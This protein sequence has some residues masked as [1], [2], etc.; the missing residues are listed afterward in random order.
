MTTTGELAD[1]Q[2]RIKTA[3]FQSQLA[4]TSAKF[5]SPQSG[6]KD[7]AVSDEGL[8]HMSEVVLPISILP[9]IRIIKT[10]L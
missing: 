3:P 7:V 2:A 5:L 6:I 4:S 10:I 1:E 8:Y 9:G